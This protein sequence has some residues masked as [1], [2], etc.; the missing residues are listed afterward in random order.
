MMQWLETAIALFPAG[1]VVVLTAALIA[2]GYWLAKRQD[3]GTETLLFQLGVW[4]HC[5]C[6]RTADQR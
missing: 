6:G 3:Q 1:V 2:A 4:H 5:L